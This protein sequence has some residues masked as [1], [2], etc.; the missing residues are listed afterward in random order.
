MALLK[1]VVAEEAAGILRLPAAGIDP[2]RP[3][4][5]LGMD[6]LM[7]VELRNVLGRATQAELS[8]T[9]LFDHPTVNALARHL[10]MTAFADLFPQADLSENGERTKLLDEVE[11]L[12]EDEMESLIAQEFSRLK[13]S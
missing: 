2:L 11:Q 3:L 13:K 12:S 4:S 6:S 7:A 10:A 8:A 9:L 5:E 1:T